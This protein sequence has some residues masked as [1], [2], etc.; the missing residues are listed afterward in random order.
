MCRG[1]NLSRPRAGVRKKLWRGRARESPNC[2][3]EEEK[4]KPQHRRLLRAGYGPRAYWRA[5]ARYAFVHVRLNDSARSYKPHVDEDSMRWEPDAMA[6]GRQRSR[7]VPRYKIYIIHTDHC[8]HN[9]QR[10]AEVDMR[11]RGH[12]DTKHLHARSGR[13]RKAQV[14]F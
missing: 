4:I 12:D 7:T 2:R 3:E 11:R 6:R 9:C 14:L 5:V 8:I 10:L 13:R 1:L